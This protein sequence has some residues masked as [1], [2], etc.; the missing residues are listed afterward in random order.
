MSSGSKNIIIDSRRTKLNFSDIEKK[1]LIEVKKRPSINKVILI[2]KISPTF[3][4]RWYGEYNKTRVSNLKRI[5][6]W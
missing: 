4:F 3:D 2:D 5:I 1:V 6:G